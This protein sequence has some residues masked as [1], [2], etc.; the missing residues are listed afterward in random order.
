MQA[1]IIRQLQRGGFFHAER[2]AGFEVVV[3]AEGNHGVEP[4]VSAGQLEN[5]HDVI[6]GPTGACWICREIGRQTLGAAIEKERQRAGET[7]K[8]NAAVEEQAAG[9]EDVIGGEHGLVLRLDCW[10]GKKTNTISPLMNTDGH[11]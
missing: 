11:R 6:V 9:K 3:V 4:V 1:K 10:L 5:N 8:L 2:R 7:E